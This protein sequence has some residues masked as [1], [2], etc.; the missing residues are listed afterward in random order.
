MKNA[1]IIFPPLF[2]V[3][4]RQGGKTHTDSPLL[5]QA[6]GSFEAKTSATTE[7]RPLYSGG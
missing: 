5:F 6:E 1:I 2:V 4:P 3:L 7:V